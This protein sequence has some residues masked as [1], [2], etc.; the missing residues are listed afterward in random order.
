MLSC[1]VFNKISPKPFVY[2]WSGEQLNTIVLAVAPDFL[3]CTQSVEIV[4]PL[5]MARY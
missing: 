4:V 1:T 3:D 2:K 5:G